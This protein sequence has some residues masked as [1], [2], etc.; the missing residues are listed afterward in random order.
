MVDVSMRD[1]R[2]ST[3]V[4]D[5]WIYVLD[6]LLGPLRCLSIHVFTRVCI[7]I[8]VYIDNFQCDSK[9]TVTHRLLEPNRELMISLGSR[10][11]FRTRRLVSLV[12]STAAV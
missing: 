3:I 8:Y 4:V 10:I 9:S 12:K 2:G 11:S 6:G 7:Y 1:G 5:F